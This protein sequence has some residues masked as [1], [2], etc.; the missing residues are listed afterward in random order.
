MAGFSGEGTREL[1]SKDELENLNEAQ[2]EIA[3]KAGLLDKFYKWNALKIFP[4]KSNRLTI[5]KQAMKP[6][7]RRGMWFFMLGFSLIFLW[8]LIFGFLQEMP[9]NSFTA[10]FLT[11]VFAASS[12]VG[13]V[14]LWGH[15]RKRLRFSSNDREKIIIESAKSLGD[16]FDVP[17]VVMGHSHNVDLRTVD[18]KGTIYANSG[19]WTHTANPWSRIISD[20][21]KMTFVK[22]SGHIPAL[23]RWNS[24]S[25][26]VESVPLFTIDDKKI[27]KPFVS[28]EISV[29][30]DGENSIIPG[31]FDDI[32]TMEHFDE[33]EN[34]V[35]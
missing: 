19:T 14:W 25:R 35:D 26:S 20:A 32:S 3:E 33:F 13:G 6:L 15:L 22:I 10:A 24:N 4:E 5:A 34:K 21:R 1:Q 30:N 12:I 17:I 27:A 7:V 16:L 11:S 23:G 31:I 8:M 29:L 9:V 2:K 28:D 18:S